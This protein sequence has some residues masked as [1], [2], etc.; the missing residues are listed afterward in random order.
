[1]L[2]NAGISVLLDLHAAPG[3]QV[4]SNPFA[5][6]CVSSPGF[7]TQ[8]NFDR[9]NAAAAALTTLIHQEPDNFGSVWGLEALNGALLGGRWLRLMTW[10]AQSRRRTATRRRGTS[11]SCR[12]SSTPYAMRRTRSTSRTPTESPLSSWISPGGVLRRLPDGFSD[13][14]DCRQWQNNQANPAFTENGGNA[15]DR[16]VYR[17]FMTV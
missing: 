13:F 4:A 16:S 10:L 8:A 11:R 14:H 1:M 7:W 15:Y 17:D 3:A 9:L 5:G 2:R 12:D 6:R